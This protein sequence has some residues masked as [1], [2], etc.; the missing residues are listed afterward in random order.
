MANGDG[1][2]DAR[3]SRYQLLMCCR[4]ALQQHPSLELIG[5]SRSGLLES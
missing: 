1:P 3:F 4:C 5:L 2:R